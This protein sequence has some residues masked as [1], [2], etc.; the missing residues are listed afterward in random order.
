VPVKR[1]A[2]D[3]EE[4]FRI[5]SCSLGVGWCICSGM[6]MCSGAAPLKWLVLILTAWCL[7]GD[8][9][10][11]AVSGELPAAERIATVTTAIS[12]AT[13]GVPHSAGRVLT[14]DRCECHQGTVLPL[15]RFEIAW[16]AVSLGD[17]PSAISHLP[18]N[19]L[20]G[21]DPRPPLL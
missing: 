18:R 16:H 4:C 1:R 6:R 17:A 3:H 9:V 20:S 11:V 14:L 5:P 2:R 15:A 7:N 21:P 19:L 10:E 8:I 12:G 13:L